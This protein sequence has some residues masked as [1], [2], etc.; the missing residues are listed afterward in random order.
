MIWT[1]KLRNNALLLFSAVLLALTGWSADIPRAGAAQA[2]VCGTGDH[3]L[4]QELQQKHAK[5]DESPLAF[6]DIQFLGAKT[7]RGAGNGFMIG[8]SDGGCTFQTIYEGQWS[9]RKIDFPDNVYGWALASVQDGQSGYLIRTTDGGSHW[10]RLSNGPVTF[11]KIDFLDRQHGFAYDRAFAYYTADGGGSWSKIP[12]PA[13]T[14]G[15]V[16]T[17]RSSGWVVTVAPGEGYRIRRTSDGGKSWS[18]QLKSAFSY[19]EFGDIYAKGSQ[20]WAVLYG[21]TGMSQTSYSLYASP[22]G[23]GSW[24]RV[25]A[26]ST[27]GGGPAPGSGGNPLPKG[28]VSGKPG[29]MQLAGGGAFLL[30]YSPAGEQVGVGRSYTGGRQWTNLP[31]IPGFD[32]V[33][34]FAGAKEGWLAVRGPEQSSLYATQDGGVTW[35]QKFS[36]H[37]K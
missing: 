26:Q 31:G 15:A 36:F 35:K 27:A 19:P 3:G 12:T 2:P 13:N 33:I 14:R 4:L 9:F 30:G 11:T 16:F 8:T 28:P 10:K 32:G 18:L 20:V 5:A 22:D 1:K 25:I 24:R 17:S 37:A 23:G 21:G 7:G 29:N 34:S 6:S